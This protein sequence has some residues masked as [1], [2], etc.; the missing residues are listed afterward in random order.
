MPQ[1][2]SPNIAAGIGALFILPFILLNAIVG[3][4]IEPFISFIRPDTH[5]SLLEIIL[6]AIAWLLLPIGAFISGRPLL[7]I[8]PNGKRTMHLINASVSLILLITFVLLSG[9]WTEIYQC[10]VVQ[11]PNCD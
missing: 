11:I 1:L 2:M 9:L 6:L 3:N 8:G 4:R 5:T 7:Q 10:E